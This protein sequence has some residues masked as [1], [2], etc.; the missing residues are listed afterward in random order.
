MMGLSIFRLVRR[1]AAP[2]VFVAA[3]AAGLG[4]CSL[5]EF[6]PGGGE[7]A[8]MYVLSPKSTF[9]E[10]LAPVSSQLVIEVP[11]ASEGINSHGIAVRETPL[12]LDYFAGVRWTERAPFMIQTLLVES[13]ENSGKIVSVARRGTD[14]R[15]D[16]VLK[17][18]LREFQAEY[19]TPESA[20]ARVRL[21]AKLVRMP[22]RV[23]LASVNF[24][25]R[26]AVEGEGILAV[27]NAFDTALGKVLKRTVEWSLREVAQDE[28]TRKGK[29]RSRRNQ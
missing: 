15:A 21:N 3:L 27:V 5:K 28:Q 29:R 25:R 14:L 26:I 8:D 10:T 23:I 24:E 7:R 13:F 22:Q 20:D 6:I 1:R 16:Y 12:T 19:T 17:T 11:I 9:A 18:E 4:A 2:V